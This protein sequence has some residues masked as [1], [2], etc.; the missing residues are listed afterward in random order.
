MT[1]GGTVSATA[2]L[3]AILL[4]TATVG[5]NAVKVNGNRLNYP[6]W[7]ILPVLVGFLLVVVTMFKPKIAR[8][9]API[10]AAAEGLFIGAISAAFNI[11][12]KGIV[13]QAIGATAAVFAVMLFLYKTKIIKVT[14]R[15]RRIVGGAVFGVMIFYG[16][17]LLFGAF[18]HSPSFLTK[19]TPLG[20]LLSLFV[21]G[22]AAFNL[23]LSFDTIERGAAA[24]APKYMEWYAALGLMVALVWLYLELLRLFA[25][26]Q[27]RR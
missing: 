22:L 25:K 7:T 21:S 11:V 14:E 27:S 2:A 15:M 18:G 9:T 5:W 1:V 17:S 4:V 10:Y 23:A 24:Q 16:I 13:V 8:F 6:A 3:F 26:L 12:Y 19:G 20:I